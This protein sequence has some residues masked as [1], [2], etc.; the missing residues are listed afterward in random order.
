MSHKTIS[1]HV[2]GMHCAS[3]ASNIQRKL[4]KTQGVKQAQVNYANEQATI[5]V[6]ENS[7]DEST[8]HQ[9]VKDLGY[10]AHIGMHDASDLSEQEREQELKNLKKKLVLSS[11]FTILLL[12]GAMIPMAPALLKN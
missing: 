9:A 6:D 11:V 2:S 8:A 7:F 4:I 12:F 10:T 1:F 3:C 5:E